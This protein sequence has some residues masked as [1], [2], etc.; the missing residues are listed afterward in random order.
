MKTE[1]I[2]RPMKNHHYR[3]SGLLASEP[4]HLS[5]HSV[6]IQI[7][8]SLGQGPEW[9]KSDFENALNNT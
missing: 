7:E 4:K 6:S 5:P 1:F 8:C 3:P 2:D 9:N